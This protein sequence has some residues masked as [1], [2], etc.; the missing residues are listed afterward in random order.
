MLQPFTVAPAV[1]RSSHFERILRAPSLIVKLDRI[2]PV[3]SH[4]NLLRNST[5]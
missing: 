1:Y 5:F 3:E 2:A 4:L